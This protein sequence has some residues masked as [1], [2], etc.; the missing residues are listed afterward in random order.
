MLKQAVILLSLMFLASC[1]GDSDNPVAPEHILVGSW[2]FDST[3]MVTTMFQSS[4]YADY[5]RDDFRDDFRQRGIDIDSINM[6]ALMLVFMADP[7]FAE[8]NA[9]LHAQLRAAMGITVIR[10][11]ADGSW[12]DSHGDNGTWRED[13]SIVIM[14]GYEIKYFVDGDDLILIYPSEVLLDAFRADEDFTD[15]DVVLFRGIFDEDTNI[16]FFFKRK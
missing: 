7:A 6:D 2:T 14:G 4:A 15:E 1:G 5:I 11:N 9:Q 3:D 12:E 8:L 13:D 10:F 16:R